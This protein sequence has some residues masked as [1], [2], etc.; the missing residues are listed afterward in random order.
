MKITFQENFGSIIIA[1]KRR[2]SVNE[3][4]MNRIRDVCS[5]L[6][7]QYHFILNIVLNAMITKE[8]KSYPW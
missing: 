3:E 8:K 4:C 2:R 7:K 6:L 1:K 5:K